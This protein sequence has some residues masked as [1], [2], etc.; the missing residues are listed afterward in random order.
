MKLA[1]FGGSGGTGLQLIDKAGAGDL[2][3]YYRVFDV[4]DKV[5]LVSL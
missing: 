4:R 5:P 3:R 1:V 2:K